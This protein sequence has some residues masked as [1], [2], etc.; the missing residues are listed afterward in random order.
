MQ[1]G[2]RHRIALDDLPATLAEMGQLRISLPLRAE[3]EEIFEDRRGRVLIH[4]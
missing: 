2:G 3:T 1:L 4:R